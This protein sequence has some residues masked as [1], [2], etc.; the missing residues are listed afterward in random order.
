MKGNTEKEHKTM[1][2]NFKSDDGVE[3]ITINIPAWVTITFNSGGQETLY[4][5]D[6]VEDD[7]TEHGD[8]SKITQ[9]LVAGGERMA[10]DKGGDADKGPLE[11]D[12]ERGKYVRDNLQNGNVSTGRGKKADPIL[13]LLRI[14]VSTLPGVKVADANKM[15]LKQIEAK[16]GTKLYA[17]RCKEIAPLVG[18]SIPEP[19]TPEGDGGAAALAVINNA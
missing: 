13:K 2:T 10:N 7:G 15:T 18:L 16:M 3:M 11:K 9:V 8:A 6:M 4:L 12:R 19:P 14:S 1:A 5:E 17:Q